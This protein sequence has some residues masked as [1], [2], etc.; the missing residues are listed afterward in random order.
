MSGVQDDESSKNEQ[1]RTPIT[2]TSNQNLNVSIFI[3]LSDRIS[4]KR[5]PDLIME[6]WKRDTGY[7][8]SIIEAFQNHLKNKRVLLVNDK[9]KLYFHPIPTDVPDINNIVSSLD[10]SF[11]KDNVTIDNINLIKS[12]YEQHLELIY[13]KTLDEKEPLAT[14]THDP[15]PGSDIFGFF[16]SHVKDYCIKDNHRN[17]LFILTDGYEYYKDGHPNIDK[18]NKSNYLLS[19]S[20]KKWGF[21]SSNFKSKLEDEGYD[22]QVPVQGLEDLEVYIIGIKPQESWHLDVINHYWA[23]WMKNM[24]VK[25]FQNDHWAKYIKQSDLPANL[26]NNIQSFVNG[27]N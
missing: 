17:I 7:I 13:Q 2:A 12:N 10:K 1:P 23:N 20:L 11:T 25:N 16:K 6:T 5:N 14:A 3:D 24:G 19:T 22:F 18:N 4:Q 21:N 26:N 15:Y 9:I 8:N 27:K